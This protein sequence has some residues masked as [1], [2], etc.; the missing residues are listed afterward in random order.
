MDSKARDRPLFAA[1]HLLLSHLHTMNA[2]L[3]GSYSGKK[4]PPLS[5]L[6][7]LPVT[8]LSEKGAKYTRIKGT[9][10]EGN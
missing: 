10:E 2:S 3:K 5:W 7:P 8:H 9:D 4:E 6:S 1:E